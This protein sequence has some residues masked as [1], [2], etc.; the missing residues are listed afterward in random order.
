MDKDNSVQSCLNVGA[1]HTIPAPNLSLSEKPIVV[2]ESDITADNDA[3]K[4][5]SSMLINIISNERAYE[6]KLE[7]GPTNSRSVPV[8][9]TDIDQ[10]SSIF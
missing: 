2:A 9:W 6:E 3:S 8:F 1:I 7:F 10:I 4:E 5:V